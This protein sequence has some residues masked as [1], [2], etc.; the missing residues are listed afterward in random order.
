MCTVQ[1]IIF[2][3]VLDFRAFSRG[4]TLTSQY[5]DLPRPECCDLCV[6]HRVRLTPDRPHRTGHRSPVPVAYR[7]PCS[8]QR[9]PA[10]AGSRR[11][12][13]GAG[14]PVGLGRGGAKNRKSKP[15]A[16]TGRHS[17]P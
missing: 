1:R 9:A 10:T 15:K 17:V 14:M 7:G 4:L 8:D 11:G 6:H 3:G 12:V 16:E 2:S 5:T 13:P